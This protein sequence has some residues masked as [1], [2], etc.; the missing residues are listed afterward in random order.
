MTPMSGMLAVFASKNK[1]VVQNPNSSSRVEVVSTRVEFDIQGRS[2]FFACSQLAVSIMHCNLNYSWGQYL[3]ITMIDMSRLWHQC[4]S[5]TKHFGAVKFLEDNA[6]TKLYCQQKCQVNMNDCLCHFYLRPVMAFRY[7]G[8]L[9]LCVCVSMCVCVS[10]CV[11]I[12]HL[13]VHAITRD[14]FKLGSPNLDQRCKTIWL[15]SLLFYGVIDLD[16]QGQI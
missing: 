10:V 14:P 13:L 16:L 1:E 12:N 11:S 7:C 15:R 4:I 9:R 5:N 2:H 6:S 3:L 8:C